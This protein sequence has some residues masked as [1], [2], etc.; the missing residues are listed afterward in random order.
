[1]TSQEGQPVAVP[2]S[3]QLPPYPPFVNERTRNS[4]TPSVVSRE[5]P[6]GLGVPTPGTAEMQSVAAILDGGNSLGGTLYSGSNTPR[7]VRR[8][9][10]R[11]AQQISG[12]DRVA[13]R[14]QQREVKRQLQL[15]AK[16][17]AYLPRNGELGEQALRT[18]RRLKVEPHRATSEVL[19]GAY[20]FLAE[21]GL[22]S[23]GILIGQDAWSGAGFVYDPWVLYRLGILTNPN[24]LLA[25]V[26]G[27]GKSTLAKSIATRS[28]AFGRKCYVP[29]DPKGEWT[30]VSRSVGGQAIAL[31]DGVAA[32]LN[33]LDEG[34]RPA[35]LTNHDGGQVALSD[36]AWAQ[37]VRQR[38][39]ELLRSITEAALGRLM[40]PV[41]S[42]ALYAAL[43]EAVATNSVATL[44]QVVSAMFDP[45]G[46]VIGSNRAQLLDDGRDV[47]HALNRL[48]GGDLGGLF[49]GP[50]TVHFDAT[51]PMVSLDLS[52]IQGSDAKIGLVMTCAS[53]WMEAALQDPSGGQRWVIYDEAWRVLKQPA[54]LARMQSQWKLSRAL[55]IANLMVIHRLS[56]LDAVGERDSEARNLAL[57]LLAD[58]STK[59]IY[60]QESGEDAKT[61]A[62]LGLSS[63]EIDQLASL[64]RGEGLWRVGERSFVVRHICTPGELALFDTNQRM[65]S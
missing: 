51:L 39:C 10:A 7:R 6:S 53:S 48:V 15:E 11:A 9:T 31:G 55:G 54:L 63:T 27:R 34:P 18:Y 13:A 20:P 62:A 64:A 42:T 57:G 37:M 65:T 58:C 12:A 5:T 36:A 50:S 22:G 17:A 29:G 1:V 40:G 14:E 41:E 43:D 56:D 3:I 23:E 49:D 8:G 2:A 61:G 19:A 30:A 38:R 33:P 35:Y 45:P 32:R 52:R 46:D 44:P 60:A 21:S 16:A 26:V 47:A 4:A 25:G 28:I 59:I 24:C